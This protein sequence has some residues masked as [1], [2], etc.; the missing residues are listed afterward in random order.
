MKPSDKVLVR[1][2]GIGELINEFDN[3]TEQ[4][5]GTFNK[6][7][8]TSKILGFI[9]SATVEIGGYND[10][11]REITVNGIT[12]INHSLDHTSIISTDYK[13][14]VMELYYPNGG[15]VGRF[16]NFKAAAMYL[17]IH[18]KTLEA[19]IRNKT[20]VMEDLNGDS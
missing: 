18:H 8:P 3:L 13:S 14:N 16:N 17:N 2:K 10:T 7:F 12:K 4:T 6:T 20:Y 9:D 15:F 5:V 19:R 1:E 11:F